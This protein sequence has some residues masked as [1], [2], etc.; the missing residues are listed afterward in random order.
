MRILSWYIARTFLK[1]WILCVFA[2]LAFIVVANLLGNLDNIFTGWNQFVKYLTELVRSMPGVLDILFPMTVLLATVLTFTQLGRTSELIAM[3]SAG[4]GTLGQIA[5]VLAIAACIS[6]LDYANQNYLHPILSGQ[7]KDN[8]EQSQHQ[9]LTKDN[10][11]IYLGQVSPEAG[12][13]SQARIMHWEKRPFRIRRLENIE[14]I[15]RNSDGPWLLSGLSSREFVENSWV[16]KRS[17]EENRTAESFP[18]LFLPLERDSHHMPF[19]ELSNRIRQLESQDRR[20]NMYMVSWYQKMAA[21]CAP[22]VLVFFGAP[23]SQAH[24]RKG[25]ASGELMVSI[26]GG[27]LFLIATEIM[28]TLGRGGFL[29]PFVATWSVNLAF[30][31]MSGVLFMRVR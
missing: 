7:Q 27:L 14:R 13:V 1:Y 22:L 17:N 21:L 30:L 8:P 15:S 29:A 24:H 25:R 9:W 31:A 10:Q 11:L 20:T 16:L 28:L 19:F 4:M 6:F 23:L 18:N 2:L 3:R 26:L 5:P 12:E